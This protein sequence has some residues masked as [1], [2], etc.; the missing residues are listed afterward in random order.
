[1]TEWLEQGHVGRADKVLRG[2][3]EESRV[4]G[5]ASFTQRRWPHGD[6]PCPPGDDWQMMHL[7]HFDNCLDQRGFAVVVLCHVGN[8]RRELGNLR[9]GEQARDL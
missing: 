8:V 5:E 4:A 2:E 3:E 6:A 7:C 9:G 1:L